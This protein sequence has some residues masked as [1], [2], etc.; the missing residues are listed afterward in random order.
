MAKLKPKTARPVESFGPELFE[1]LKRAAT[2]RIDF[3]LSYRRATRLRQR[4]YQLREA[5]RLAS[6]E[7]YNLVSRV[8]I[9]VD[10][11]D[12][13]PV[14]KAGRNNVPRDKN[15]LCEVILRPNDSEFSDLLDLAGIT[16]HLPPTQDSAAA[17]AEFESGIESLLD[18]LDNPPPKNKV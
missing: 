9:T 11:P 18:D 5:M 1:L 13:T 16:L 8:R 12:D 2:T 15:V 14:V 4:L 3:Q 6:H 10:W 17:P 7:Q